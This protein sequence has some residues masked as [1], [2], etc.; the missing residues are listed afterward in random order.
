MHPHPDPRQQSG[1]RDGGRPW[2]T[3][4]QL[5]TAQDTE[6][7]PRRIAA[8]VTIDGAER[9]PA[10][11]IDHPL[12]S[13]LLSTLSVCVLR[14]AL[15]R[16]QCPDIGRQE[17]RGEQTGIFRPS[18][19]HGRDGNTARHLHNRKQRIQSA[20]VVGGNRHANDRHVRFGGQHPGR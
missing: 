2:R 10:H 17:L 15:T 12:A 6:H 11:S 8:C 13:G 19:R 20:K 18:D 9:T 1:I 14:K 4:I 5:S 3:W 7:G 16:P